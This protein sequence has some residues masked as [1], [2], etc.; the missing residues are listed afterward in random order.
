MRQVS[1]CGGLPLQLLR[2]VQP[3]PL[4][5][6]LTSLRRALLLADH[7]VHFLFRQTLKSAVV[8]YTYSSG[9]KERQCTAMYRND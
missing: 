6:A 4:L 5:L 9:A 2:H 7:A 1:E 3:A 8:L